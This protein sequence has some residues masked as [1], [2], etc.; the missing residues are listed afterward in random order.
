MQAYLF[1]IALVL[2]VF[3]TSIMSYIS[4]ATP[5]GPWIAPTLVLF[6]N[7]LFK[8]VRPHRYETSLAL[9]AC[10]GSVGGIIATAIAFSFPTIYFLDPIFFGTLMARPFYFASTLGG[11]SLTAGWFGIWIANFL[12]R[13]LIVEDKLPF[14]IGTIINRMIAAHHSMQKAYEMTSAFFAS[15]L[16]AFMQ[17]SMHLIAKSIVLMPA[18]AIN[19]LHMPVI[20]FD[21]S[22][23]LWAIGFVT[24]HVMMVPLAIGVL[25]RLFIAL[26]VHALFFAQ[27]STAME[28]N[29]AFCS[30]MVLCST[31]TSLFIGAKKLWHYQLHKQQS[32]SPIVHLMAIIKTF[33]WQPLV[34]LAAIM[35][36][37]IFFLSLFGFTLITQ[38]YL[39]VLTFVFTRQIAL[40][41][42]RIGIAPLGTFATFVMFPALFIFNLTAMQIVLIA[43]FVEVCGGVTADILFGR[44]VAQL[45][46][47]PL[48][49]IKCYQYVGLIISSLVVGVVFWFL[50]QKFSLG[51]LELFA[52]KAQSRA[53]LVQ[54]ID[55]INY[56]AIIPGFIFAYCIQWAG[57]NSALVLGGLLMPFSISIGLITG[58]LLTL[59]TKDKEEW[60]P[61]WSGVFAAQSIW[62][63]LQA[64]VS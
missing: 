21:L 39:L 23:L 27:G 63:L 57:M 4:L 13:T 46:D 54:I 51:S 9:V 28:F 45:S 48:A 33:T 25:S 3:A 2:S 43:T 12:E 26:P 61:A 16:F 32:L 44:K 20:A 56:W 18:F 17:N 34:E 35:V 10:A 64:I 7:M 53:L 62:M 50:I 22:P 58:G 1:F 5:I 29:F 42:G 49:R 41:A 14:P 15:L 37:C 31:I 47:I 40:I 59:L 30:G 11:L 24:G 6:G 55:H 52:G 19:C 60:Y 36:A 38:C 8:V